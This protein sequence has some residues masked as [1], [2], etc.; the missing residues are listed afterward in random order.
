MIQLDYLAL[1]GK[2]VLVTGGTGFIGRRLVEALTVACN[3][4]VRVMARNLA[5]ATGV[6]R[7]PV[8]L[9]RGDVSVAADVER[10]VEGCDLVFHCAAI[11]RANPETARAVN[12]GGTENVLSAALRASVER[13]VHISSLTVYG[14]PADGDLDETAPRQYQG[15]N[16]ADTK[17]DAEN[18]AF[19]YYE[20]HGLPVSVIQP[21]CVY[22]PFGGS[23]TQGVLNQLLDD[24]VILVGEGEGLANP[25]YVDDVVHGIL[26]AAVRDQAIGQAFLISDGDRVTWRE[27]YGRYAQMVKGAEIVSAPADEL[28]QAHNLQLKQNRKKSILRESWDIL[29]E[30]AQVRDRI[31]GTRE[32][33]FAAQV[34]RP[35]VPR[36]VR[37][38]LRA[39]PGKSDNHAAHRG[40]AEPKAPLAMSPGVVKFFTPKARVRIDKAQRLLGYQPTF[41]L[42][43]GLQ[44]VEQW[45]RWAKIL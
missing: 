33:A 28:I 23:W 40:Q 17:L 8:E 21:A 41:D 27:F 34:A 2:R 12:V 6:A 5:R 43:A 15:M 9:V 14:F 42:E 29:R 18:I 26:L 10:A 30:D 13:V 3:V 11:A 37:E 45:A 24:R 1:S 16:Y 4:D 31:F 7:F 25:V 35:F 32:G 36:S 22:G 38:S 19:E 44:R 20:R 39:R